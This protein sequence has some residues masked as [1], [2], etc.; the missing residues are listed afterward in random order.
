MHQWLG[1]RTA[2]MAL[3]ARPF[4]KEIGDAKIWNSIKTL[5]PS[6]SYATCDRLH[7][8]PRD[9]LVCLQ[10]AIFDIVTQNVQVHVDYES[11]FQNLVSFMFTSAHPLSCTFSNKA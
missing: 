3:V 2:A 10:I 9:H 7:T 5:L 11:H 1:V 8:I 6:Y 4:R